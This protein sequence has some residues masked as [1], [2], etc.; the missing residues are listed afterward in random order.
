MTCAK[1]VL[2]ALV[3]KQSPFVRTPKYRVEG[4]ETSWEQKKYVRRRGGW[5]PVIELGLAAYFLSTTAYSFVIENYLTSPF[6][7]LFFMGY[8]YMGTMSLLQTP[9]RR[10]W[11]ALP[12]LLRL[13]AR[14]VSPAAF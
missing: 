8:S 5:V 12:A 13:R 6:L 2:E 4:R 9:F 7:L 10:L 14:A 11:N 1:A 3:G